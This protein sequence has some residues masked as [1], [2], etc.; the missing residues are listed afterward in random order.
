MQSVPLKT[1]LQ[2]AYQT[3]D[4][5]LAGPS[6]LD[7][8]HY[9]I[10]AKSTGQLTEAELRLMFRHALIERFMFSVRRERRIVEVYALVIDKN[11]SKLTMGNAKGKSLILP[12]GLP[13]RLNVR[14]TS[15]AEVAELLSR[16]ATQTFKLPP[17]VDMTGL[18]GR[19][20]FTIEGSGFLRYLV[21]SLN[22]R[23]A[24]ALDS[25][26]TV[27]FVQQILQE[28]LGLRAE[29]R[30]IPMEMFVVERTPLK[31]TLKPH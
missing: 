11:E 21:Q 15:M 23:R 30:M 7:E 25:P 5:Q 14:D 12:Q 13:F 6:W 28:Q 10:Q 3:K 16:V 22:G 31:S 26:R 24:P 19:Y 4:Y 17:V 20:N 8:P 29:L 18:P 9:D 1:A 2:W 27:A